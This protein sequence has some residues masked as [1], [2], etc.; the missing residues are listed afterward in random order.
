MEDCL[1]DAPYLVAGDFSVA[2][3]SD[4][5]FTPIVVPVRPVRNRIRFFFST[6][7][8]AGAAGVCTGD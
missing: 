4:P 3:S 1:P 5:G 2:R 8:R 7:N 6:C